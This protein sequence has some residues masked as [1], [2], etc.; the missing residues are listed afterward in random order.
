MRLLSLLSLSLILVSCG[1]STGGRPP[2]TIP[3]P[4]VSTGAGDSAVQRE[5]QGNWR[6][7]GF[8]MSPQ[9]G[10]SESRVAEGELTYDSFGNLTVHAELQPGQPGVEAPRTVLVDFVTK[11]S[12]LP[13]SGELAYVGLRNRAPADRTVPNAT[14]PGAWRHYELDGNTLRLSVEDGSGRKVGTLIFQRAG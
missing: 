3:T 14:D 10:Q 1:G 5:L 9:P 11:A 12:P 6:L 2:A 13:A 8:E 4:P 7:V